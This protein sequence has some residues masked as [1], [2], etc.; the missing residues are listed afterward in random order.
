[1]RPRLLSLVTPAPAGFDVVAIGKRD[2]LGGTVAVYAPD[3][4]AL[5]AI[6]PGY[7]TRMQGV[8]ATPGHD[9]S[10]T[11][12]GPL[13]WHLTVPAALLAQLGTWVTPML[14]M[15]NGA[16]TIF[17]RDAESQSS[18]ARLRQELGYMREDYNRVTSRL[19]SKLNELMRTQIALT[20]SE[21]RLRILNEELERRVEIRTSELRAL[22][23]ELEAFSYSVSHDLRAPLRAIHGFSGMLME[24]FEQQLPKEAQDHLHRVVAAAQRMDQL[25]DDLIGLARAAKADI[26]LSRVDLSSVCLRVWAGMQHLV[27]GRKIELKVG[28]EL[29]AWADERLIRV[30]FEN[31]LANAVKFTRSKPDASI[32]FG[33]LPDAS[34]STFYVRD[35][36]AGFDMKGV[37]KL[38]APFQRLHHEREFEGT[39]IGLATAKRIIA[40]HGG[41]IWAEGAVGEGATVYFTLPA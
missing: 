37:D 35:N 41:A 25:I 17:D 31:L 23:Q 5:T 21:S 16:A 22:N 39:G 14:E 24:D 8:I 19:Q 11:Q 32:E 13:L 27:A 30:V 4:D 26:A 38:F 33:R 12:V 6:L 2:L 3:L 9:F 1:M 20:E 36:G 34:T 29:F 40:R 18:I 28:S 10:A 7:G 15:V